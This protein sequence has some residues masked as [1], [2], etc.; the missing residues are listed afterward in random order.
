[1][2]NNLYLNDLTDVQCLELAAGPGRLVELDQ[3]A[4]TACHYDVCAGCFDVPAFFVDDAVG[5]LRIIHEE[6]SAAAAAN[7]GVFH[8]LVIP[9][10]R[11]QRPRF[12]PDSLTPAQM[13][14]IVIRDFRPAFLTGHVAGTWPDTRSSPLFW[15]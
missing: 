8:F 4:R 10:R 13:T 11:K 15:R 5:N 3:T 7:I 9:C 12:F 6:R 2:K 14:G 1:M